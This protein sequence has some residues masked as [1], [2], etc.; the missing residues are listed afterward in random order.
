MPMSKKTK[1]GMVCDAS[2]E[3]YYFWGAI[4][5]LICIGALVFTAIS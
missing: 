2:D 3:D 4:V 1:N 5:M